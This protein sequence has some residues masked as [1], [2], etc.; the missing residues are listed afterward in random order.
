MLL[1]YGFLS[2]DGPVDI[3]G[4]SSDVIPGWFED[5]AP[6]VLNTDDVPFAD[7]GEDQQ[8]KLQPE[9][10]LW[11]A[12]PTW[13]DGSFEAWATTDDTGSLFTELAL[14]DPVLDE[15]PETLAAWFDGSA[16]SSQNYDDSP[17]LAE[18]ASDFA[19]DDAPDQ[20]LDD[21]AT[22]L[23]FDDWLQDTIVVAVDQPYDDTTDVVWP[24][25]YAEQS[26]NADDA[27]YEDA[28]D[29]ANDEVSEVVGWDAAFDN[30]DD[31]IFP[32][33]VADQPAD[34][35]TDY[36]V[37]DWDGVVAAFDDDGS[38][39][40]ELA[41]LAD[42]VND[43]NPDITSF[44]WDGPFDSP[45]DAGSSFVEQPLVDPINDEAPELGVFA[46]DGSF[47]SPDDD[48]SVYIELATADFAVDCCPDL[49]PFA[50]LYD[51][52]SPDD[53]G[54][55][56]I[57]LAN[58]DFANDCCPDVVSFASL[59]DADSPDDSGA[60][61]VDTPF[62]DD[63]VS[64]ED[65]P[66]VTAIWPAWYDGSVEGLSVSG[67]QTLDLVAEVFVG[68]GGWGNVNTGTPARKRHTKKIKSFTEL[69]HELRAELMAEEL[70]PVVAA[71]TVTQPKPVT[72]K[73]IVQAKAPKPVVTAAHLDDDDDDEEI[74]VADY[75][76]RLRS[77]FS[78]LQHLMGG[79]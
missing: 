38:L 20:W 14:V 24:D 44:A 21:G 67:E 27:I 18:F 11:A 68:A 39:Y 22:A 43:D 57:E 58:T 3:A 6:W 5:W 32:D 55:V 8:P 45:D 17:L 41:A 19:N 72:P 53:D 54:S 37:F 7:L 42:P 13:W 9:P 36:S 26:Q 28:S 33:L 73:P 2:I 78:I 51:A 76:M 59:Y 10:D 70:G 12:N 49:T 47:D 35:Y 31:S 60:L 71:K 50:G 52:D 46:W 34:E 64:V 29:F 40:I 30:P 77:S 69:A 1:T 4:S 23:N 79:L 63:S 15:A 74:L 62:V 61:F 75:M 56:Y 25:G 16:E 65:A 66:D 48:G